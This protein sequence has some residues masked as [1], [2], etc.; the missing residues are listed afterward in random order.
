MKLRWV[1]AVFALLA[2][3]GYVGPPQPPA[4]NLPQPIADLSAVQTG[5]KIVVRFTTPTQTTENLP[6]TK[7]RTIELAVG[8]DASLGNARH[9][10]IPPDELGAREFPIDAREWIG[11]Q[12]TVGIRTTGQ[13]GRESDWSNRRLISVG[14]PLNKP[15][16]IV[17][18]NTAQGV[19]LRWT[20]NA[21]R[22]RVFRSILD[23]PMPVFEMAGESDTAEFVDTLTVFGARYAYVVMGISGDSQE[24]PR[25]EPVEIETVDKFAPAIPTGL[26]AS[27]Q[28]NAV[29]LSWTP[30]TEDDLG[31]YNL[32]RAVDDGP[33]ALYQRN[34][35]LPAY[36][37]T[38]VESGKRYRYSVS[39]I[40][41]SGNE[42]ER[43]EEKS[44][45]V[46]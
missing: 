17:P 46:E 7:L 42:S 2:G 11:Q 16:G 37:D 13:S 34:L 10:Q 32:F 21:S 24:S 28:G 29:D 41:K 35:S 14:T 12:V 33:F 22:Y 38:S 26:S 19:A 1:T 25:S 23:D 4:L 9:V 36:H 20:G 44:A 3:C 30:S 43:A 45:T 27:S 31:G 18:S 15:T 39:A 40:D 8:T 5:D 6:I